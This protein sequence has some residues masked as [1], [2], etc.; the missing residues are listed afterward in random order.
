MSKDL[1]EKFK[2]YCKSENLEI[3]IKNWLQLS[4]GIKVFKNTIYFKIYV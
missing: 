1:E 4:T 2:L 3:L